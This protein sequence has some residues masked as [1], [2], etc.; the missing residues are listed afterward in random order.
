MLNL[1]REIVDKAAQKL[2]LNKVPQN[3]GPGR[4]RNSPDD[5]A[6]VV[7]MAQYFCLS[8]RVGQGYLLLFK[9]KLHLKNSFSYKTVERTYGD[10]LVRRILEEVF[11]LTHEPVRELGHTFGPDGIGLSTSNK[12]NYENDRRGGDTHKGYEKMIVMVGCTYKLFSAFQFA[13]SATDN[14]SPYFES[15]LAQTTQN[16][17]RIDLV[18]ADS[19]Y[20]SRRN[21]SL[22]MR[23]G[24]VSRIYPKEGVTMRQGGS[25]AWRK[26]FMDLLVDPQKW[27]SEYH[28]RSNAETAFS[29]LKRDC[30]VPL[31]K[32][33]PLRK[34]QEAFT[35][36]CNYN[37]KRLCYLNY[38]EGIKATE[39]WTD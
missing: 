4:P 3:V 15:L 36:A 17:T 21:C 28:V 10:V 8:N 24:A 22:A 30:P 27:L 26:M 39:T 33:I 20:L 16:Y 12:Q 13:D 19:A 34:R 31:R 35:R 5:E 29:S 11:R 2:G 1:I 23:V 25:V 9:E 7:L 38:I 6:K 37:L 32:K 14:E 18:S